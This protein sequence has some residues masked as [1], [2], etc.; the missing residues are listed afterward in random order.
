M[1]FTEWKTPIVS[2][3]VIIFNESYGFALNHYFECEIWFLYPIFTDWFQYSWMLII[4]GLY[5]LVPTSVLERKLFFCIH[6][7]PRRWLWFL[8]GAVGQHREE[9]GKFFSDSKSN[10]TLGS[11]TSEK[12]LWLSLHRCLPFFLGCY[13]GFTLSAGTR[14][15]ILSWPSNLAGNV[16]QRSIWMGEIGLQNTS[17]SNVINMLT[18]SYFLILKYPW[19]FTLILWQ[20]CILKLLGLEKTKGGVCVAQA[21]S[22]HNIRHYVGENIS[23]LRPSDFPTS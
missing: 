8:E 20:N 5:V 18:R 19:V 13:F 10:S 7:F 17:S 23:Y 9:E 3:H 1:T 22:T 15:M 16:H 11:I 4:L 2:I 6:G 14:S 21:F 12:M